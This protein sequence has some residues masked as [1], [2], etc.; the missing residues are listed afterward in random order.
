[1]TCSEIKRPTGKAQSA[2]F[3]CFD[4]R[5]MRQAA[6]QHAAYARQQLTRFE[7]LGQVIVRA[8]LKSENA[9]QRLA[10]RRQHNHRQTRSNAQIS[11]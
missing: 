10:A 3:P 1:M 2:V 11:A 6:A 7:R 5:R 8:H 4:R 9:I